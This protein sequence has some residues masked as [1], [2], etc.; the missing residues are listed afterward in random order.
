M[1]DRAGEGVP[2]PDVLA[3]PH[4]DWLYHH[5]R[6]TG[7]HAEVA[8]FRAAVGDVTWASPALSQASTSRSA[9]AAA[10]SAAP[11]TKPK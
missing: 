7:G 6:V 11:V 2:A 5:L 3:L 4:P 1:A 8:A 10:G 9:A